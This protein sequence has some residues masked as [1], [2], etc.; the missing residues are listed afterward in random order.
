M[1]TNGFGNG[2]SSFGSPPDGEDLPEMYNLDDVIA[3]RIALRLLLAGGVL[4][5]R[6]HQGA[7]C[8]RPGRVGKCRP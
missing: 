6:D 4:D 2:F 7:P 8:R 1:A 3:L 5:G